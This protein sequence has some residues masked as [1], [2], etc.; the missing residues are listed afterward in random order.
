MKKY[1]LLALLSI[2]FTAYSQVY[3]VKS[4]TYEN[5]TVE[6]ESTI[7]V[8]N[9]M[10]ILITD[11]YV[12]EYIIT[13]VIKNSTGILIICGNV[14]SFEF[15]KSTRLVIWKSKLPFG[16]ET[17]IQRIKLDNVPDIKRLGNTLIK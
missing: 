10:V 7:E 14:N 15:N 8:K 12:N 16:R 6:M 4:V 13:D 3:S 2:S 5:H 9:S 11:G 1:I 17:T